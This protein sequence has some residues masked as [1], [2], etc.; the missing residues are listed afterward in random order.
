MLILVDIV[1]ILKIHPKTLIKIF[2]LIGLALGLGGAILLDLL[3]IRFLVKQ[4]I[5]QEFYEIFK[6]SSQV[7]FWGLCL[8]WLS[9]IAYFLYYYISEH[10]WFYN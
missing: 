2:H 7:V 6:H 10:H 4:K 5:S 1:D 8:L 9:G 3:A